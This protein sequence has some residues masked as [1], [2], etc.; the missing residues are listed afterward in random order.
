MP[1][2]RTLCE[3]PVRDPGV[4]V[5][6]FQPSP[7]TSNPK[8]LEAPPPVNELGEAKPVSWDGPHDPE[9]PQNWSASR[10]WLVMFVNSII[11]VN[12]YVRWIAFSKFVS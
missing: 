11:T 6:K 2:T 5:V 7:D 9:N 10:K 8:I 3:P 12:V 1:E 4:V